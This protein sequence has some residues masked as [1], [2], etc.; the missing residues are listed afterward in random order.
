MSNAIPEKPWS[1]ISADFVT[2]LPLAQDYNIILVICNQ[3]SK[4]VHFIATMEKTLAEG[5]IRL[6]RDHIWKLHGLLGSIILDREVQFVAGIMRELSK[7]LGIQTKLSIAYYPQMDGQMERIN[8]K[9]EQYLRVFID[10]K[11]EQWLD[12]LGTAKFAYNNKFHLAT[13]ASPFKMNYGQDPRMGFEERRKGKFIVAG[14]FVERMKK[15]QE[16]AK[17]ALGKV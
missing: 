9:L 3:S 12:W 6:F 11:Q 14:K 1:Y 10:H 16:K 4:I 8:Q 13:K 17:V 2:K 7:L 15:I 5:L